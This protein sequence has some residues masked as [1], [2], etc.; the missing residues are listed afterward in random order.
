MAKNDDLSGF[1][2]AQ[3]KPETAMDKTARAVKEIKEAETKE[4]QDKMA[5]L[6]RARHESEAEATT[7]P[8]S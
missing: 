5:R 1:T 8:V 4:R 2:T 7:K 6:R 3:S